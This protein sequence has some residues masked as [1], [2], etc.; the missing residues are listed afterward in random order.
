VVD[1]VVVVDRVVVD[2]EHEGG[3]DEA[4]ED[5]DGPVRQDLVPGQ[6]PTDRG[7][8]RDRRVDVR[9]RDATDRVDGEH[10]GQTPS[11]RDQEPVAAAQQGCVLQLGA[12]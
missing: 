12:P 7:A 5:L 6:V 11:P 9:T 8:E 4:P 10:D 2:E 1:L 3:A